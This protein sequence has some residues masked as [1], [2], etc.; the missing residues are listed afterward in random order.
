MWQLY[1]FS[2]LAGLFAANGTPHFIKG[3]MGLKHQTP[4][5][6]HS[7]AVVNVCWGW[8]NLVVA[9]IFLHF[10]HVRTHEYRAF[11]LLAVAALLMS[12]F[13]ANVWS[14]QSGASR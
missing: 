4:F 7:S 2:F 1:I 12:L 13:N 10:A 11:V 9:V 6:K 5:A 14:K 8:I 3:A